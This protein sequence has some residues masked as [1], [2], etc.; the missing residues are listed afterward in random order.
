MK[1]ATEPGRKRWFHK[2]ER[3]VVRDTLRESS[4]LAATTKGLERLPLALH[5]CHGIIPHRCGL[6]PLH[7]HLWLGGELQ[8]DGAG[9][10]LGCTQQLLHPL[11]FLTLK[12]HHRASWVGRCLVLGRRR[13][14]V[15]TQGG[16]FSF[17][18]SDPQALG[19]APAPSTL[20]YLLSLSYCRG[21]LGRWGCCEGKRRVLLI[22]LVLS[23]GASPA[24]FTGVLAGLVIIVLNLRFFRDD[25]DLL[26]HLLDQSKAHFDY[27]T[28]WTPPVAYTGCNSSEFPI[29]QWRKSKIPTWASNRLNDWTK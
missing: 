13:G 4:Q 10:H 27:C 6:L 24:T 9:V 21:S 29:M 19:G 28:D 5:E 11:H 18:L 20:S 25:C 16:G 12:N 14:R 2:G 26:T 8:L 3:Q 17:G 15:W 22:W 1:I 7:L 23:S